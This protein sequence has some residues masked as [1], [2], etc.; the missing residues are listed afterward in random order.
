LSSVYGGKMIDTVLEYYFSGRWLKYV[1]FIA[2]GY[3][4]HP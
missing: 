4:L 1:P 3:W 2:L